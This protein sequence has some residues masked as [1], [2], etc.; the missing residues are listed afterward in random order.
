MNDYNFFEP[1]YKKIKIPYKFLCFFFTFIIILLIFLYFNNTIHKLEE[2]ISNQLKQ[3]NQLDELNVLNT[4]KELERKVNE[5]SNQLTDIESFI[6]TND[7]TYW[8]NKNI[9]DEIISYIPDGLTFKEMNLHE[10]TISIS[11]EA[12]NKYLIA[13][14]EHYLRISDNFANIYVDSINE[15]INGQR[16]VFSFNM[17][18]TFVGGGDIDSE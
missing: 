16:R 2:R 17:T 11:A 13:E 8:I 1:F 18:M 14:Y 12:T 3:I 7:E 5:F 15:S 10:K 4:H 9:I 6:K